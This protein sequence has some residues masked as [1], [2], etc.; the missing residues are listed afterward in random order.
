MALQISSTCSLLLFIYSFLFSS[1]LASSF[2]SFFPLRIFFL[3][4][5]ISCFFLFKH[6]NGFLLNF[7]F[8]VY[9][10]HFGCYVNLIQVCIRPLQHPLFYRKLKLNFTK[11]LKMSHRTNNMHMTNFR[12]HKDTG[13]RLLFEKFFDVFNEIRGNNLYL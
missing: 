8:L 12:S 2:L 9:S 6:I 3:S 5:N 11:F 4:F 1:L 10:L 13:L 7:V